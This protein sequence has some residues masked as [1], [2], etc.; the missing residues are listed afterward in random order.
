MEST[1]F[2]FAGWFMAL[3]TDGSLGNA[4]GCILSS[5]SEESLISRTWNLF[6]PLNTISRFLGRWRWRDCCCGERRTSLLIWL[7][8]LPMPESADISRCAWKPLRVDEFAA[9]FAFFVSIAGRRLVEA[10]TGADGGGATTLI[11]GYC[12][13]GRLDVCNVNFETIVAVAWAVGR[14]LNTNES[15]WTQTNFLVLRLG[16]FSA[17]YCLWPQTQ[18]RLWTKH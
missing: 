17:G 13:F 7:L 5:D 12:G 6:R 2:K 8:I 14:I 15:S 10:S 1:Y 11:T 16:C 9:C 18:L 4:N 3:Q